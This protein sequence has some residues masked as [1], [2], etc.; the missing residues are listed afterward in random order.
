[1]QK[2]IL[3]I[4]FLCCTTFAYTQSEVGCE[5][6]ME[7]EF[8]LDA[9]EE[10]EERFMANMQ[11]L[12][13]C[14]LEPIDYQI[15]MGPTGKPIMGALLVNS[16]EETKGGKLRFLDVKKMLLE[17]KNRP[18]YTKVRTIVEAQNTLIK[19]KARI[20]NWETDKLLLQKM[21]LA[22]EQQ[23]EFYQLVK[24]NEGVDYTAI[25]LMY[26]DTLAAR[27]ER[28]FLQKQKRLEA[29]RK[30]HPKAKEWTN[31]LM[32]YDD[33]E[34]G[35]RIAKEQ[36]K[37][38]LLYFHGYA[39]VNAR[40][41]EYSVLSQKLIREFLNERIVLIV[42]AVDDKRPL[43]A[44]QQ[45]ESTLFDGKVKY[46]GQRYSELQTMAYKSNHQPFFVLLNTQGEELASMGYTQDPNVFWAFLQKAE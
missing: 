9:S 2:I 40:K 10:W 4:L 42:L 26:A 39:C 25:F 46:I 41:M 38:V 43:P 33:L 44:D 1:M 15:F 12:I 36:N 35:R 3:G 19:K 45:Y 13:D 23:Q 37:P 8:V 7:R 27:K 18:E 30:Q 6:L 28:E 24:A 29:A 14:A 21:G 34:V 5:A 16:T 11:Q 20:K 32:A 22:S 17:F 31:G